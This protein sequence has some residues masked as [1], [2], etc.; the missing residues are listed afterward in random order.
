VRD[1]TPLQPSI[2]VRNQQYKLYRDGRFLDVIADP[3][4]EHPLDTAAL[5]AAAL[6]TREQ[7]QHILDERAAAVTPVNTPRP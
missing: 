1:V 7:F 4:E 6:A 3:D 2:L 5:N